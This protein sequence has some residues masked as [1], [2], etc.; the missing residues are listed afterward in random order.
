MIG[1]WEVLALWF[2]A[3]S[4][5]IAVLSLFALALLGL[6]WV[7]AADSEFLGIDVSPPGRGGVAAWM[8]LGALGMACPSQKELVAYW[9]L[10]NPQ[11]A[12]ETS[13]VYQMAKDLLGAKVEEMINPKVEEDGE[14]K[15]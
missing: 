9:L 3:R 4:G 11:L 7:A 13:E 10:T 12:E 15:Q 8:L 1:F 5:G 2:A 14:E 6:K